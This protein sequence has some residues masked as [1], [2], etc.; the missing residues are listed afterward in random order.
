MKLLQIHAEFKLPDDFEGG[1]GEALERLAEYDR[2]TPE[3][4]HHDRVPPESLTIKEWE[5]EALKSL[6]EL[7]QGDG[8][9]LISKWFVGEW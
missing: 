6:V 5:A 9:R 8:T 2:Q 7:N 3:K 4:D 1:L